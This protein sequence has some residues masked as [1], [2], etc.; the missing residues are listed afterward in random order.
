MFIAVRDPIYK[1][2]DGRGGNDLTIFRAHQDHAGTKPGM[3]KADDRSWDGKILH[4]GFM[5]SIFG[6]KLHEQGFTLMLQVAIRPI[7]LNRYKRSTASITITR[8]SSYQINSGTRMIY[9]RSPD[10]SRKFFPNVHV[11]CTILPSKADMFPS[12]ITQLAYWG[13]SV[14]TRLMG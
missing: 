9:I 3:T 10:R 13:G 8:S 5:S 7:Q 4:Q 1:S 2:R 6:C 12:V 11:R 14:A